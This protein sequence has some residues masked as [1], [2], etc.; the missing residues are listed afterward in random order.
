MA[1]LTDFMERKLLDHIFGVTEM[2]KLTSLYLG[3]STTAFSESDTASQALAKEPGSSGT[4]YNGNGYSRVNVYNNFNDTSTYNAG[5]RNSSQISFPEV[6]TSNW[7]DIGYWALYED[8]L[9]SNGT[10]SSTIDSDN[11]QKP[12]MIGSFSAAVTTNVGDQFKIASGD[13]DIT[14]PS[15]LQYLS[16]SISTNNDGLFSKY[17][18]INLMGLDGGNTPFGSSYSTWEFQDGTANNKRFWLGVSTSAFGGSNGIN[19]EDSAGSQ[20]PGYN[21]GTA[22]NLSSYTNNGYTR[23]QI[24]FSAA[25][26]SNGTTTI[27]NSNAVEFPEATSSWGDITHFAIFCGGDKIGTSTYETGNRYPKYP[28]GSGV[29]LG[30]GGGYATLSQRR[31]FF[32]GALDAT[33]TIGSGDT[34]RFPAGSI[35]I[36]LD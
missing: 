7:G 22:S 35:S 16:T 10:S 34:L 15:A 26:T 2:T 30:T 23:P 9:P 8:A 29:T 13:F 21:N 32:I 11:G 33:K 20:E 24:E 19:T 17:H 3:I 31:P 36:A 5:A 6:T 12:L 4:T 25:S 27:T 14:L 1:I 28:A 18:L